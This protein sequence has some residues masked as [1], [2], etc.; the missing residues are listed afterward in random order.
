MNFHSIEMHF[1]RNGSELWYCIIH[2]K[3]SFFFH[4]LVN[5]VGGVS[6]L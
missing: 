4:L 5:S 6:L 2:L 3:R 1:Y